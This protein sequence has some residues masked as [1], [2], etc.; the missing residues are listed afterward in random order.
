MPLQIRTL[1]KNEL[2]LLYKYA[3]I[4]GWETEEL[5][6]NTLFKLSNDGFFVA[7]LK[8]Q[9][10]GFIVGVKHSSQ[11]ASISSFLIIKQFRAQGH[12][13]AL[14]HHALKYLDGYQIA[15]DS[16]INKES[17]YLNAGFHSYF[18][19]TTYK[20]VKG[21]ITLNNTNKIITGYEKNIST[22]NVDRETKEMILLTKKTYKAIKKGLNISSFGYL[23]PFVDGQKIVL[24]SN[25]IN[26]VVTLFFAIIENLPNNTNIY[27]QVTKL[28]PVLEALVE[29]LK[30]QEYSKLTRMYNTILTYKKK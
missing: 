23:Y 4:E 13:K 11:F 25:D 19:T 18:D 8:K 10:I 15:L 14:L 26:E 24:S 5:Y 9:L 22:L 7:F 1:K 12:G 29:A 20:F 28:T 6:I 2:K 16:V 27:I 17:I 21:S 30:M 3:K